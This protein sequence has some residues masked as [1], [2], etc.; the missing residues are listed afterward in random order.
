MEVG[1][2]T[3]NGCALRK[4]NYLKLAAWLLPGL[5]ILCC[6]ALGYY[7]YQRIRGLEKEKAEL[8]ASLSRIT[9]QVVTLQKKTHAFEYDFFGLTYLGNGQEFMDRN[10]LVYG[11]YE[12][13][14]LFLMK[15]IVQNLHDAHLVFFDI[16]AFKGQHSLFMSRHVAVIHAFEP[17]PPVAAI[18][19]Q[20]IERNGIKNITLWPVALGKE[21]G[22]L[23]FEVPPN[24]NPGV[25]SLL[26]DWRKTN[27]NGEITVA[28]KKGDELP[29]EVRADVDLIKLDTEGYEKNIV[30]GL[31]E[32][33]RSRRPI[34]VMELN[35]GSSETWVSEEE[36]YRLFPPNY[37]MLQINRIGS[38]EDGKY[39]LAKLG[40]FFSIPTHTSLGAPTADVLLFPAE[41]QDKI[42]LRNIE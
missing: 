3:Y 18:F 11:A 31:R 23:P 37:E 39:Q 12:K 41:K 24:R 9:S 33:L 35:V 30:I 36:I 17:Y 4:I 13:H 2:P 27:E 28:I 20:I 22:E 14:E 7:S 19:R 29:S 1:W 26:K 15:D 10:V 16:G 8:K 34:V 42:P 5:L 6:L 32:T 40:A 25:G 38:P 21:Q